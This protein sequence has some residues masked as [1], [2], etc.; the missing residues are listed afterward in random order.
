M[1]GARAATEVA[2]PGSSVC[3][4]LSGYKTEVYAGLAPLG[5]SKRSVD[6]GTPPSARLSVKYR[7]GPQIAAQ[8]LRGSCCIVAGQLL[9]R[10]PFPRIEALTSG[11]PKPPATFRIFQDDNID[12]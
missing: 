6:G 5:R 7:S 4:T 8:R 1:P 10:R 12:R 11:P 3:A 9:Y 2:P